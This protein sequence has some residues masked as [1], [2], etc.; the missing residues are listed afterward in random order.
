[1][2]IQILSGKFLSIALASALLGLLTLTIATQS[3][4]PHGPP[5]HPIPHADVLRYRAAMHFVYVA[6]QTIITI[7]NHISA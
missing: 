2:R 7:A 5:P 6:R 1:M 4:G 3:T